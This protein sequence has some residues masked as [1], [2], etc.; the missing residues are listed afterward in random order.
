LKKEKTYIAL[1]PHPQEKLA[2]WT[3]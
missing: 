2:R 3:G 1:W